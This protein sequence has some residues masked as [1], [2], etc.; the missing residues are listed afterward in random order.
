METRAQGKK[1]NGTWLSDVVDEP[2]W[3]LEHFLEMLSEHASGQADDIEL[4]KQTY[5]AETLFKDAV[6][7]IEK[8]IREMEAMLGGRIRLFYRGDELEKAEVV[9]PGGKNGTPAVPACIDKDKLSNAYEDI[10]CVYDSDPPKNSHNKAYMLAALDSMKEV[11]DS[12]FPGAFSSEEIER[13]FNAKELREKAG[14]EADHDI[15]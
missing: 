4:E 8:R 3:A 15:N 14:K 9:P 6:A 10:R 1:E 12:A 2:L 13:R 11:L 7:K 5:I